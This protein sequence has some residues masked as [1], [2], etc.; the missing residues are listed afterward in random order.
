[1]VFWIY[2]IGSNGYALPGEEVYEALS[3]GVL[4]V[5]KHMPTPIM[6]DLGIH[7]VTKYV[8]GPTLHQ[9]YSSVNHMA[10]KGT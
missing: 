4:D 9:P 7:A 10:Y 2:Y 5:A 8:I 3:R 6:K 1:M